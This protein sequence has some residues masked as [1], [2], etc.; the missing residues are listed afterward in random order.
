MRACEIEKS[1]ERGGASHCKS[2]QVGGASIAKRLER[3]TLAFVCERVYCQ[4]I[5]IQKKNLRHNNL[6]KLFINRGCQNFK[7]IITNSFHDTFL[8]LQKKTMQWAKP[9]NVLMRSFRQF[10]FVLYVQKLT[11]NEDGTKKKQQ[12]FYTIVRDVNN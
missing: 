3:L 7:T 9:L 10:F 11:L 12:P 8:K 5:R 2:S 1:S 6:L 4:P